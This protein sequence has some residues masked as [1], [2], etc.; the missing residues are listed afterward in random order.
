MRNSFRLQKAPFTGEEA[1]YHI[2]RLVRFI[3]DLCTHSP[4]HIDYIL[5]GEDICSMILMSSIFEKQNEVINSLTIIPILGFL[6]PSTVDTKEACPTIIK[7]SL[8][9]SNEFFLMPKVKQPKTME[10]I[11]DNYIMMGVLS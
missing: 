5:C 3:R 11:E 8:C 4:T 6:T 10:E 2:E 1:Q 9:K 7:T